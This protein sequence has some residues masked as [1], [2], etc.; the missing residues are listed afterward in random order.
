MLN[1]SAVT[2]LNE[3]RG[4]AFELLSSLACI[5]FKGALL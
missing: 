5:H 1:V 4:L 2:K 3:V